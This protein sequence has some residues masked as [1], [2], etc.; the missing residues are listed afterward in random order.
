MSQP[1]AWKRLHISRSTYLKWV[2]AGKINPR[3][4]GLRKL[5]VLRAE[6][7]AILG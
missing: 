4:I 2:K 1:E 5:L 6:V 3:R 7:D